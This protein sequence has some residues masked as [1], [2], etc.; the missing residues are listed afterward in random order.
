MIGVRSEHA[1]A[2]K[3]GHGC[4]N[5]LLRLIGTI[6]VVATLA[7][8]RPSPKAT[9]EYG[10]RLIDRTTEYLGPDVADAGMRF[11]RS[12]LACASCHI[13]AGAEPGELSLV[14]ADRTAGHGKNHRGP[15]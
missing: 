10:K 7:S 5:G 15:Y 14:A 8:V 6:T 13:R 1:R 9:Q 4:S 3:P 2:A 11:T 12:R